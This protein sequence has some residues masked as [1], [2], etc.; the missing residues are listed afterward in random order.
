MRR[1]RCTQPLLREG[2]TRL[3]DRSKR[4]DERPARLG[5]SVAM[6]LLAIASL[7]LAV[8]V[9]D[10]IGPASEP[11]TSDTHGGVVTQQRPEP[12]GPADVEKPP[13]VNVA[14]SGLVPRDT[15]IVGSFETAPPLS[16]STGSG[17]ADAAAAKVR[18]PS[19]L[20]AASA[21]ASS[22]IAAPD[23]PRA[24]VDAVEASQ[25][26]RPPFLRPTVATDADRGEL[27]GAGEGSETPLLL[28]ARRASNA[29]Y[30]ALPAS[31]PP[32]S[33]LARVTRMFRHQTVLRT[34]SLRRS[35]FRA[36]LTNIGGNPT[37]LSPPATQT[38][39]LPGHLRPG[40]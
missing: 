28:T 29:G 24:R 7:G 4:G 21:S 13:A 12:T 14:A 18:S 23:A 6:P 19:N 1:L 27:A 17:V 22:S 36:P 33:R 2:E 40:N 26:I 5:P 10:A 31:E 3:A 35:R 16:A 20:V 15:G 30:T 38:F 37:P 25:A 8:L 32:S 9:V 11:P 34:G 39:R